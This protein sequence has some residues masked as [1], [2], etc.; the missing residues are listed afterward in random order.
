MSVNR[1][2]VF[3]WASLQ[4]ISTSLFDFHFHIAPEGR[5][6]KF[7]AKE[8]RIGSLGSFP[9]YLTD[10]YASY[11]MQEQDFVMDKCTLFWTD[12]WM[13]ITMAAEHILQSIKESCSF[14]STLF[15]FFFCI[16]SLL[17]C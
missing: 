8:L 15:N 16:Y 1:F 4:E 6:Q 7:P 3:P 10:E 13:I 17:F 14:C 5:F 9:D 2:I 11:H 12:E